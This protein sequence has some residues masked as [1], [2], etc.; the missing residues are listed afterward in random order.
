MIYYKTD[1]QVELIRASCQLVSK[2]LAEAAKLIAAGTT[3]LQ[4]DKA[5][6]AFIRDHGATPVFLGYK[7]FPNSLCISKNEVVVH[8]IPDDKPFEDGDIVSVD[9][10]VMLNGYVGDS[11][12][13]FGVGN[14]S[15]DK[16]RL[17][18]VTKESLMK[19]V[20]KAVVGN[21]L[22]DISY[23]VQEYCE[24]MNGFGVVRELVG[25]GV[26]KKLHEDPEVPN[27]GKRGAGIKLLNGLVIAIEPMVNMGTR[28]VAQ[29]DD[30]W[31]IISRDKKPSAHFEHT[32]AVRPG[33][34]DVLTT[35]SFIE[36]VLQ[37]E[38]NTQKITSE[39]Q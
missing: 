18:Q 27:Y 21:R 38:N 34:A 24:K 30:G 12:Y 1:E 10:G 29:L 3:P 32:L 39:I 11:A 20:D 7:G 6:E 19:A 2:T 22:G 25:H 36:E 14:I 37:L 28:D 33:K 31:T 8:G 16:Q 26:G 5:C 13:T 15:T 17:L 35:F 4:L 23:A 9:C